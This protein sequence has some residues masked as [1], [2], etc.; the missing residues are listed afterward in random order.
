M[1]SLA[2]FSLSTIM[3]FADAD[4]LTV[5]VEGRLDT[6]TAPELE[7]EIKAS[8]DGI[9]ELVF[10]FGSLE[11]I[12]SAGLR[13]LLSAQKVMNKQGSMKVTN[14]NEEIMEIFEVTGFSD[15]LT[16]E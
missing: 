11:Y 13:V 14:V 1:A 7:Q 16:I 10:D 2:H 6:T 3:L 8:T 5:K 12:S 15:I 4:K 9:T